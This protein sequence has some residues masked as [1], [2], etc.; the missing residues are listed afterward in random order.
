[1][2]NISIFLPSSSNFL[3]QVLVA[4]CAQSMSECA[5]VCSNFK[6]PILVQKIFGLKQISYFDSEGIHD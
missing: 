5:F 1:M 4:G 2:L 3:C 6:L